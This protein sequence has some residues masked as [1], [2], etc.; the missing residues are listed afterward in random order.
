M[1]LPAVWSGGLAAEFARCPV[2]SFK[3]PFFRASV[4]STP[5]ILPFTFP[6]ASES[7]VD[8]KDCRHLWDRRETQVTRSRTRGFRL[9]SIL[10]SFSCNSFL[11]PQRLRLNISY[12]SDVLKSQ[13]SW[14]GASAP[15]AATGEVMRLCA[16]LLHYLV[17]L[18]KYR[19][20]ISSV[21]LVQLL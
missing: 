3:P 17:S 1:E 5:C 11:I 18:V 8:K 9:S 7:L 4:F 15:R 10:C 20:F 14:Q 21:I 19:Q 16:G 2:S 13:P 6:C 12:S